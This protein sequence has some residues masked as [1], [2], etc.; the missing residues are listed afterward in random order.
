MDSEIRTKMNQQIKEIDTLAPH[1]RAHHFEQ[2]V[3]WVYDLAYR[4]GWDHGY[5][6]QDVDMSHQVSGLVRRAKRR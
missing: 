3:D 1:A 6:R 5:W 4:K 2:F